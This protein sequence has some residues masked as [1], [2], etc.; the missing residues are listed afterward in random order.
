MH[1]FIQLM[2]HQS[3]YLVWV[4][5]MLFCYSMVLVM[6]RF[7]GAPGLFVYM[8]VMVIAANA[9]V[10][11]MIIFPFYHNPVGLGTTL[12]A[13]TYLCSDILAE[14]YGAK[15]ARRGIMLALLAQFL[16]VSCMV[17]ALSFKPLT[18]SQAAATG[19]PGIGE[20]QAHLFGVFGPG[21]S[22]VVAGLTSFFI[23]QNTDVWIFMAMKKLFHNRGLW[24][25]NNVSTMLAS[26][27]DNATFNI[28]AFHVFAVQVVPW[29]TLIFGYVFGTYL[30]RVLVSLLDTPFIYFAKHFV[31]KEHML[32]NTAHR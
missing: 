19:I 22:L 2:N 3:F 8:G 29:H 4:I 23:S 13:T 10:T 18:A 28:L 7:F 24:F 32:H 25:R 31:R 17:F 27:L 6:I 14:Y 16:M 12:F 5:Q 11:K 9:Q 15:T 30:L 20:I 21:P 26:L 1:D